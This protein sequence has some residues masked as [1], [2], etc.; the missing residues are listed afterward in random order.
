MLQLPCGGAA[1]VVGGVACCRLV[2]SVVASVAAGAVWAR[3]LVQK[4][5][6]VVLP[7]F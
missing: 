3:V 7:E 2:A 1:G 4:V 5:L 6:R